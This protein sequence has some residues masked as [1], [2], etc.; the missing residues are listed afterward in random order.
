MITPE[1]EEVLRVFDLVGQHEANSLNRLFSSVDII[2]QEQIIC[3]SG[4]SCVLE[5]L[6][7][8]G[9]LTVNVT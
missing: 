1:H 5:K 4:K 8:V 7:Q 3:I 9:V 2:S 6:Y